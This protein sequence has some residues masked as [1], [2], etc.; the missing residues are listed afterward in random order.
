MAILWMSTFCSPFLLR[1][2]SIS[3]SI[4]P[5]VRSP[6][7][8]SSFWMGSR[9]LSVSI[10]GYV[11]SWGSRR[12]I[13]VHL[14]WSHRLREQVVLFIFY[15]LIYKI[16]PFSKTALRP[17]TTSTGTMRWHLIKTQQYNQWASWR[18]GRDSH[19][20]NAIQ[21]LKNRKDKEIEVSPDQS[22]LLPMVAAVPA[23][24]PVGIAPML[25]SEP[26][27]APLPYRVRGYLLKYFSFPPR[28]AS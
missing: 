28:S 26:L 22:G 15:H 6:Q 11:Y 24:R 1:P 9:H 5:V 18:S 8:K 21:L 23:F 27:A 20:T 16:V 7:M 3:I 13:K 14:A 19:S 10:P 17:S 25:Q 12:Q 4:A 2:V